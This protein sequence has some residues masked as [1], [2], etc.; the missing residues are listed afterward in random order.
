M[1][2]TQARILTKRPKPQGILFKTSKVFVQNLKGFRL[3]P[4]GILTNSLTDSEQFPNTFHF[5]IKIEKS[6]YIKKNLWY[7]E[8]TF[9]TN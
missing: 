3:K 7:N 1:T 9:E 5:L 4:Q 8:W 2:L 6:L